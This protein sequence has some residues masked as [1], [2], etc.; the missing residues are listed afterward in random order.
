[1][2]RWKRIEWAA[3]LA[4]LLTLLISAFY[5]HGASG[6]QA[7]LAKK[8][9][10]LHVLANSDSEQDQERKL[11]VKDAV[12]ART[13]ELLCQAEDQRQAEALLADAL[14]ELER[15]AEETLREN[16]STETV[17]AELTDA[18]FFTRYYDGFTLPAGEYRALR[19]VIGEGK[20]QNWWCVV[21]P[22]LCS[23]GE[24]TLTDAAARAGLTEAE[25]RLIQSGE[26]RYLLRFRSLELLQRLRAW[27]K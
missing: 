3:A 6:Q 2:F 22:P 18:D 4:L 17:A 24:E 1:M 20:G 14:P 8:M 21:Y 10:R 16:G 15:L 23:A 25:L 27:L 13:E 19:I 7:A 9:V 5:L 12:F 11:L 26:G